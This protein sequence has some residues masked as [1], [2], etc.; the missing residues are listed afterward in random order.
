MLRTKYRT[1]EISKLGKVT[2]D[3]I[4]IILKM[5]SSRFSI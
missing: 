2:G 5:G 3:P 4:K 1:K